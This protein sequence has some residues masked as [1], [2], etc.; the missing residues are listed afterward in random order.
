MLLN[1]AYTNFKIATTLSLYVTCSRSI[2][3]DFPPKVDL[4]IWLRYRLL[5][6]SYFFSYVLF[7]NEASFSRKAI[8]NFRNNHIWAKDNPDAI[9]ENHFPSTIFSK[10]ENI[11]NLIGPCILSLRRL[12]SERVTNVF[13]AL[14]Y[15]TL[16]IK[17]N[18]VDAR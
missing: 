17:N 14:V 12:N 6:T 9:K 15:C 8:I 18:V 5:R 16:K 10:Y 11:G 13:G 1:I 7:T 4:S 3:S 2:R